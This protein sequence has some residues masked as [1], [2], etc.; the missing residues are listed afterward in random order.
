MNQGP[1]YLTEIA[2]TLGFSPPAVKYHLEKFLTVSLIQIEKSENRI[3]NTLNKVKFEELISE[4][5]NSFN[6]K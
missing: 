2:D 4:L 6:I 1:K 5:K 3:Y